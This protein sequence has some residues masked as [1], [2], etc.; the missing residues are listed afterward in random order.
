M[1]AL[2][3]FRCDVCGKEFELFIE[4]DKIK[5]NVKCPK[6]KSKTVKKIIK[7]AFPILFSG[8]GF[9]STDNKKEKNK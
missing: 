5:N 9:Y 1:K 6:C 4:Y 7:S 3:D 8:S 2:Y